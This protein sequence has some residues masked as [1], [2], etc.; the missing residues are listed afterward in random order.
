[1]PRAAMTTPPKETRWWKIGARPDYRFSLANERTFLAWI[2]TA[3]ALI[4]GAAA[5][6]QFAHTIGTPTLRLAIVLGLLA[7]GAMLGGSAYG[8]WR[9]IERS[10]R[11]EQDLPVSVLLPLLSC[12]AV[13]LAAALA[14][15]I[16]LG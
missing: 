1:M 13:L 6:H 9:A 2:R 16:L 7:T 10:M 5:I 15:F 3:L 11:L 14:A 8:R 12:F 4:A